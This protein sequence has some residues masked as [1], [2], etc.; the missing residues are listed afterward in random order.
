MTEENFF[1]VIVNCKT[2]T[3]SSGYYSMVGLTQTH[4]LQGDL[5]RGSKTQI[6]SW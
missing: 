1:F 5:R 3:G 2:P 4:G 6:Q